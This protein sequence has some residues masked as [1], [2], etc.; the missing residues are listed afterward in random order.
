MNSWS[1]KGRQ[2][3]LKGD[4]TLCSR[5]QVGDGSLK[6]LFYLQAI[7]YSNHYLV[8]NKVIVETLKYQFLWIYNIYYIYIIY[9]LYIYIHI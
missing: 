4:I 7:W 9:T 2:F 3:V 1:L 5:H 6:L 8:L